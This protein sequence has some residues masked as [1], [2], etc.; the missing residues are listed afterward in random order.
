MNDCVIYTNNYAVAEY[1]EQKKLPTEIK[2]FNTPAMEVLAAAKTA[3]H[4]GSVVLSS[5][6]SGVRSSIPM[7]GQRIDLQ[8]PFTFK[9]SKPQKVRALNPCLSVLIG[10]PQSTVDFDSVRNVDEA[11]V[12]YK[13]NA[14]LRFASHSDDLIKRFQMEDLENI[15]NTIAALEKLNK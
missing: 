3:A 6:M 14:R 10:S 2:W 15:L 8:P 1:F 5:P 7:F 13:K 11:L 12:I 4:L 9:D